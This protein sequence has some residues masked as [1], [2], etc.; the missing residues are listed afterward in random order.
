[1]IKAFIGFN[2][3]I[4]VMKLPWQIWMILLVMVNMVLPWFFSLLAASRDRV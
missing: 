3:G 4:L 2:K 1:M